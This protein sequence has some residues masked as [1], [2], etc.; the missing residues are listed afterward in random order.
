[1]LNLQNKTVCHDALFILIKARFY[2][3]II[4]WEIIQN[5]ILNNLSNM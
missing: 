1:M 3:N 4:K 5:F 2:F